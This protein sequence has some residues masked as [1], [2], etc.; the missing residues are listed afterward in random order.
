[1]TFKSNDNLIQTWDATSI[2]TFYVGREF[3]GSVNADV[4]RMYRKKAFTFVLAARESIIKFLLVISHAA[5][6]TC[7]GHLPSS[8][9]SSFDFSNGRVV[10]VQPGDI[11]ITIEMYPEDEQLRQVLH[12]ELLKPESK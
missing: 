6:A 8:A 10:V 5:S 3:F 4:Q 1:V 7:L 9:S 12:V 2:K 11:G